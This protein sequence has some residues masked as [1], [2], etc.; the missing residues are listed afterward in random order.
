MDFKKKY[1]KY[2]YK[3]LNLKNQKGGD[4][5]LNKELNELEANIKKKI[6][7]PYVTLERNSGTYIGQTKEGRKGKIDRHGFGIYS[8]K[9]KEHE[10]HGLW[11]VDQPIKG[12]II[13]K[14]NNKINKLNYPD[15]TN[16]KWSDNYL[17]DYHI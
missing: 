16:L 6:Y 15:K 5:E 10:F 2:K 13:N 8:F 12:Y 4:D 7:A 14:S 9:N 17:F 11:L 3:Y 1:L